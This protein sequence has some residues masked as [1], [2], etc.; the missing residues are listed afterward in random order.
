MDDKFKELDLKVN[1]NI[2]VLAADLLHFKQNVSN[3]F[4]TNTVAG[5]NDISTASP[6]RKIAR[7]VSTAGCSTSLSSSSPTLPGP[8]RGLPPNATAV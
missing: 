3:Q 8:V 6:A 1:S 2:E 7:K 5:L 4:L